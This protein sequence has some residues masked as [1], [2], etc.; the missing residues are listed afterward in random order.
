[1]QETKLYKIISFIH[2]NVLLSLFSVLINIMSF[3]FLIIPSFSAIM[4]VS[5]EIIND[6]FNVHD[7]FVINYFKDIKNYFHLS[8]I[9]YHLILIFNLYSLFFSSKNNLYT[10]A[11]IN[12]VVMSCM[13][14]FYL[15]LAY[16]N[17]E[18]QD[19]DL[20]TVGLFM[21]ADFKTL[22]F[23]F[24]V[25]LLLILS[26]FHML[27]GLISYSIRFV[28]LYVVT[29]VLMYTWENLLKDMEEVV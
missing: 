25:S 24:V 21:L 26:H 20:L 11:L 8:Y 18:K 1:M 29:I 19:F 23:V 22:L 28:I 6:E 15:Y 5:K 12:L 27:V 16:V 4:K 3:G 17:T 14:M 13:I 7:R 10:F 9:F 2:V